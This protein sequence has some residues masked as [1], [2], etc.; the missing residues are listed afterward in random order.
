MKSVKILLMIPK[1]HQMWWI[2][3][4]PIGAL[5]T[6]TILKNQGYYVEILDT[7][8]KFKKVDILKY[9]V[10]FLLTSEYDLTQCY[11]WDLSEMKKQIKDI[12][13]HNVP[14]FAVGPH[15][16][17]LDKMTL[18]ELNVTGVLKGENEI[19]IPD[20]LRSFSKYK[21]KK[22]FVFE[23]SQK[24]DLSTLPI[25]DY[26]LIDL[27]SYHSYVVFNGKV[28]KKNTGLIFANRGCPFNC[29]YCYNEFFGKTVRY[30]EV[31]MITKEIIKMK[32]ADI[33]HFFFLD[34]TFT[35]NKKWTLK[36]LQALKNL[37]ITWGC[38]TRID[39]I[40]EELLSKMSESGCKY[41]WYGIESPQIGKYVKNKNIDSESIDKI[42]ALTNIYKIQPMIFILVGFPNENIE[43]IY[44]WC[45]THKCIFDHSIIFP[46]PGT[47]LFNK[48]VKNN[49]IQFYNWLDLEKRSSLLLYENRDKVE[50]KFKILSTLD[51][52]FENTFNKGVKAINE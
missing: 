1:Y 38:Q 23:N 17:V 4:P 32:K 46:R 5:Y 33:D 12:N 42:I 36:L 15:G 41:I 45:K 47:E 7:R 8:Y 24:I 29:E 13:T 3:Q 30:R 43:E 9:D 20:F 39:C 51:N 10:V 2:Q 52:Y 49:A 31:E 27:K 40:D 21:G 18:S 48:L 37:N 19:V 28:V 6:A 34:Y 11:P 26:N 16:C 44:L 25:P 50:N 22:G 35:V 14:I